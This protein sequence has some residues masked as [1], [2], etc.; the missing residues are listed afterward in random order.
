M[1]FAIVAVVICLGCSISATLYGYYSRRGVKQIIHGE[2]APKNISLYHEDDEKYI[3]ELN[4]LI[5][6]KHES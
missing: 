3:R 5:D 6:A 1:Y 2:I 4:M